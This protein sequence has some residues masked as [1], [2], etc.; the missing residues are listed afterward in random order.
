MGNTRP[1]L[2]YITF[3]SLVVLERLKI[4]SQQLPHLGQVV[5]AAML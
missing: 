4:S 3:P 5:K 1:F 2:G